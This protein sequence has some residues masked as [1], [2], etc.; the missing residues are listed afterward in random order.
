[1]GALLATALVIVFWALLWAAAGWVGADTRDGEDWTPR[2]PD[3]GR[4]R[5]RFD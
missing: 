2:E 4:S 5:R 1:M 3:P